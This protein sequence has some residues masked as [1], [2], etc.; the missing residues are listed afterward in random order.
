MISRKDYQI[1]TNTIA[2]KMNGWHKRAATVCYPGHVNFSAKN[3]IAN[4]TYGN[5][6]YK[7]FKAFNGKGWLEIK[8]IDRLSISNTSIV[9]IF[10]KNTLYE[11][12]KDVFVNYCRDQMSWEKV[13]SGQNK[14]EVSYKELFLEKYDKIP[15]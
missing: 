9:S 6:N 12:P 15:L 2:G 10:T 3:A 5:K 14:Q 8:N 11:I 7:L 4:L 13:K 1:F